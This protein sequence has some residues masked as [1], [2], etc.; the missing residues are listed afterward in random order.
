V[1]FYRR[2]IAPLIVSVLSISC[3]SRNLADKESQ[4]ETCKGRLSSTDRDLR[5]C[6]Q[7]AVQL[8]QWK[9]EMEKT[10]LQDAPVDIQE[11]RARQKEVLSTL[12]QEVRVKVEM[13]LDQLFIVMMKEFKK[14]ESRHEELLHEFGKTYQQSAK[15]QEAVRKTQE[16][17][18]QVAGGATEIQ[19]DLASLKH[20]EEDEAARL[21]RQRQL[22]A[23][24]HQ[25]VEAIAKFD[26][27]V[28]CDSCKDKIGMFKAKGETLKFHS[29]LVRDLSALQKSLESP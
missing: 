7:E 4:L 18:E 1:K 29:M 8:Q 13:K 3:S 12:P 21:E 28:N 2:I 5:I 27:R 23:E 15:T 6:R 25:I 10:L 17:V 16:T 11:E 19:Q 20:Q 9:V 22:T 24:V 14:Q 26:G